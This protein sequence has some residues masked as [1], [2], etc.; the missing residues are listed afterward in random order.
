MGRG[1]YTC[2]RRRPAALE[3]VSEGPSYGSRRWL[4]WV[5]PSSRKRRMTD[6][7]SKCKELERSIRELDEVAAELDRNLA[8]LSRAAA[9]L[10]W[11]RAVAASHLAAARHARA[12]QRH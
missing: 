9:F 4:I 5:N 1:Q 11:Q 2:S 6:L 8:D 10:R 12:V 7:E 3:F